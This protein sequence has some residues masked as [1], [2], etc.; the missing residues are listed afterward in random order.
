MEKIPL[1]ML[2]LVEGDFAAA[3]ALISLGAVLGK[4]TP[5]QTLCMVTS[6]LVFYAINYQVGVAGSGGPLRVAAA[7]DVGTRISDVCLCLSVSMFFSL[8]FS[9]LWLFR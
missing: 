6:E 4:T 1:H 5:A 9:F 7:Q 8:F 2:Q 3:T